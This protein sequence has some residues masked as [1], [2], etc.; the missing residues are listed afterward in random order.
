MGTWAT[1]RDKSLLTASFDLGLGQTLSG[2]G[3]ESLQQFTHWLDGVARQ[4]E[5]EPAAAVRELI[6]GIDYES[7]LYESSISPKAAEM[8]MKN[9][10]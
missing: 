9:V 7:W 8:R 5:R 2:R 4:V 10:N 1:Q 3:L 6:H